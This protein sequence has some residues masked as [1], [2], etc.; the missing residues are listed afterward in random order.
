[1][2]RITIG[3]LIAVLA[4]LVSREAFALIGGGE[5]NQPLRNPGWPKG[6]AAIFNHEGRVAWW[7]GPPYGGGQWHAECRG[8]VEAFNAV[9]A[10][11]ARLDVQTKRL[12][13]HD[14]AG[15][16]FWL[17]PNA[18]PEK[19]DKARIDWAFTVWQPDRWDRLRKLPADLNP[20]DP[21]DADPP[22]KI[23]VFTAHLRWAEVTVPKGITVVDQRLEAHGFS[24]AD[25]V[26][27]EGRL[28]DLATKQPIA[29][30]IRLQ[31]IEPQKTG[32]YRYPNVAETRADAKG[33]WLLKRVSA[34]WYRIVAEA[35]GYVPR[36]AAF[37][38]LDD[39][40]RWQSYECGLARPAAVAGR[41][42]DDE[43]KPLAGVDVRIADIVP[44][45]AGRYETPAEPTC[46]TGAD[47]RFRAELLPVGKGTIRLHKPGYCRP[48]LG[49]PITLPS[50]DVALQ[51]IQSASLRVTVDFGKRERPP[52][53]VV[54][55]EPAEGSAVGTYGG[56]GNIN[57]ANQ[58]TYKNVP[59]G[60]YI[61]H[62]HPN[63]SSGDQRTRPVAVELKGGQS[64]ELT[65]EA[66]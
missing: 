61:V 6:A 4:F 65:I 16:S 53:Y 32:G 38:R 29:G 40:P 18:E 58:M 33:H 22:A 25:G 27:L 10:D 47:G 2:H 3:L 15:S 9:L 63:P 24:L 57:Q 7:E 5:G 50:H 51:M 35:E 59:P 52:G 49:L 39:Q 60:K 13:V 26:V 56:S 41:V 62:G 11:F 48:G 20:T 66:E 45:S 1:M 64:A 30:T 19:R 43:G 46:Q 34:G 42:T 36:V 55:L 17:N 21:P 31:R 14:G 54:E 23:D 37:A 12:V 44:E 28:T 8:D